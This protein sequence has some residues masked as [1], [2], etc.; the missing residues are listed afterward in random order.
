MGNW[1]ISENASEK[2]K[3][4]SDMADFLNGLNSCGEIDYSSYSKIFDF[5]MELLEKMYQL[6]KNENL[7]GNNNEGN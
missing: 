3:M 6:G 2:E 4:K 7:G 5:S 1:G